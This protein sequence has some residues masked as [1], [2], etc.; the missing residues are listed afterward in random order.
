M[1]IK[2]FTSPFLLVGVRELLTLVQELV[3]EAGV[4][5]LA[6]VATMARSVMFPGIKNKFIMKHS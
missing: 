1:L 5:V 4:L 6:G 3:V 2:S